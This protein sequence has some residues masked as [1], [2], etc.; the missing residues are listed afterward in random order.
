MCMDCKDWS[1]E[2]FKANLHNLDGIVIK[3]K[4][5]LTKSILKLANKLKFIARP[6]SGLE[7][8]DLDFL[9]E[10]EY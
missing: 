5:T 10:K 2:D 6:G 4:F 1:L 7:H 8:I 3:S 9:S